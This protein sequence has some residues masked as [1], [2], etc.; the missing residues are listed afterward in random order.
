M[1]SAVMRIS[2][3]LLAELNQEAVSTRK[4]LERV[5]DDKWDWR[6]HE[7]SMPIGL[8]A[9][10]VAELAKWG[11]MTLQT[12]ELSFNTGEYKPW[13]AK[14]H[15]ELVAKFDE[16]L[17]EFRKAL[18]DCPDEEM[19]VPWKFIMDGQLV[20]ELPR[21]AVLRSM[22]FNHLVHHRAQLGVYL[23][24]LNVPVPSAYGPSADEA[25]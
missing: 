3:A 9:S 24:L 8:L 22:V 2:D 15:N 16:G 6:P 20:F 5:P 13:L 14:N 10:H 25:N 11:P 18:Q 1:S 7:K 12:E 19:G 4:T 21:A 17:A 23:R